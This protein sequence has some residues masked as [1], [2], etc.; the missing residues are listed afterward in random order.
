MDDY[1]FKFEPYEIEN[2]WT[3]Y[4][5]PKDVYDMVN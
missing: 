4:K 2:R 1:Q 5:K 3:V